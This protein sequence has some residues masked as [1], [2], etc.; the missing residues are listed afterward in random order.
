[1][2][3]VQLKYGN[4]PKFYFKA[5]VLWTVQIK[6]GAALTSNCEMFQ[7]FPECMCTVLICCGKQQSKMRFYSFLQSY[8]H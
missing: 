6:H 5:T 3:A 1:M 4:L 7:M 8:L 2:D